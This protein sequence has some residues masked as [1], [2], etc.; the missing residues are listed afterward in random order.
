MG[1]EHVIFVLDADEAGDKGTERF[2]KL[3]EDH[4]GGHVGLKVQLVEMPDNS[5]DPD[6][7]IRTRGLDAFLNLEKVDV[8]TWRLKQAVAKGEDPDSVF[9]KT[10]PLILNEPHNLRRLRMAESLAHAT[11]IPNDV[12]WA[13]VQ[14]QSDLEGQK[15]NEEL[16]L[17]ASRTAKMLER[18]PDKLVEILAESQKSVERVS[19]MKQGYD[20]SNL[21]SYIDGVMEEA[22]NHTKDGELKLDWPIFDQCFGGLPAAD[23]FISIPGKPNQGKSSFLANVAW[24]LVDFNDD[25]ICLYHTV[26]DAMRWF[27]PRILGSRYRVPSEYFYKA[28]YHLKANTPVR[29]NGGDKQPFRDVYAEA[30]K[31]FKTKMAAERL[32]VYDASMLDQNVFSLEMRVRDLRKKYPST[33]IVVFGDNF[34]LYTNP[35]VKEDGEA[36]TR[37]LSMAC[38]NLAN[39]HHV[40]LIM[41]MELPKSA[42]EEGKRPRMMNIKGS[43]GISYDASANI[44]V[45]ND[46]KDLREKAELTWDEDVEPQEDPNMPGQIVTRIRRPVLEMV[47]DKSKVNGGFDGNIYFYFHPPSGQVLECPGPD[48][49]KYRKK[50]GGSPYAYSPAPFGYEYP[51]RKSDGAN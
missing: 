17:I 20:L 36:K 21:I 4:L 46:Q 45:Y 5:D 37:G 35:A 19:T 27:L 48:Q 32:L 43:A 7:F 51:L 26:D 33:P 40:C 2:V 23:A 38:K 25:V 30:K 31:W 44:G 41:T 3:V 22:E 12:I 1:I 24:R 9:E 39:V 18:A 15:I 11:N 47:F 50:A 6:L 13:E 8:F 28:G 42:L 14:R 49:E 34:H 29:V 16:S 10:I